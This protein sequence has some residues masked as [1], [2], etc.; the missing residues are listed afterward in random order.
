VEGQVEISPVHVRALLIHGLERV[1][2]QVAQKFD[3]QLLV[4]HRDTPLEILQP[5]S[6]LLKLGLVG[7][8]VLV[9]PG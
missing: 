1:R 8:L 4:G 2:H 3:V 9:A 5:F 7:L 6:Q